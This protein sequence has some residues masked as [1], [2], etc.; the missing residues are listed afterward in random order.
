MSHCWVTRMIY[1]EKNSGRPWVQILAMTLTY[2][3]TWGKSLPLNLFP[4]L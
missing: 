4:N 1:K 3:M 2:C